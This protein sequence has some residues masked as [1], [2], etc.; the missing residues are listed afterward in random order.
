[1]SSEWTLPR[2]TAAGLAFGLAVLGFAAADGDLPQ[3]FH[4]S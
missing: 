3:F 1:V 2:R 4:F